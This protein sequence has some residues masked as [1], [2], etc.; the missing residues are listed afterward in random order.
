MLK[1]L[2]AKRMLVAATLVVAA[3]SHAIGPGIVQ[4]RTGML[5]GS[6][7]GGDELGGSITTIPYIDGEYDL[8]LDGKSALVFR[9]VLAIDLG[10]SNVNYA[11]FGT[12]QR[13]FL[14]ASPMNFTRSEGGMSVTSN[15]KLNYFIG[16]DSGLGHVV[17]P[18]VG[19]IVLTTT[20]FDFGA[21]AGMNWFMTDGVAL[22]VGGTVSYLLGFSSIAMS[23]LAIK[24]FVG[25]SF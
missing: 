25:S 22:T 7:S 9:A 10:E 15:P 8:L 2:F 6:V 17:I 12:G 16:W 5:L 21:T 19:Q 4:I 3:S 23:G 14:G 13:F 18:K 1:G 20:A 24:A 11:Y